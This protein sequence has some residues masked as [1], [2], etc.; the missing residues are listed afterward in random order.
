MCLL[1][2]LS[3]EINIDVGEIQAAKWMK[4]VILIHEFS[5]IYL[6]G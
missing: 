1:K 6:Q 4:L 2:P 3:Y 5:F